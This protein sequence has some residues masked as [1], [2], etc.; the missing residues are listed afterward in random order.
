MDSSSCSGL[1]FRVVWL[2]ATFYVSRGLRLRLVVGLYPSKSTRSL[3]VFVVPL[4]AFPTQYT[5]TEFI[6]A[7]HQGLLHQKIPGLSNVNKRDL[8]YNEPTSRI[9]HASAY[10]IYCILRD[11]RGIPGIDQTD[12]FNRPHLLAAELPSKKCRAHAAPRGYTPAR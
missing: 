5:A 3:H 1:N 9:S 8:Q 7:S 10:I 4:A 2:P 12:F 6:F 11:H